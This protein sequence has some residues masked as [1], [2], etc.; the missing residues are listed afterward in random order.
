[1]SHQKLHIQHCILYE[2]QQGKNAAEA[3]KSICSVLGECV[4]SQNPGQPTTSTAKPIL[5]CIWWDMK[6]VLFCKLLQLGE[7]V[8]A[9]RYGR[10][11][12]DLLDGMG[13]KR[14]FT[15]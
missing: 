4:V 3:S 8:T 6:G 9:K 5:L 11:M 14:P 12:I 15:G 13:E 10:Q 7:T 2:F 1:M